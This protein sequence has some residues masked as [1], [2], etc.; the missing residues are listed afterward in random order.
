MRDHRSVT[1]LCG[2]VERARGDPDT[3][4]AWL[5]PFATPA[6][7]R[8]LDCDDAAALVLQW[9]A[10]PDPSRR[11]TDL[12]TIGAAVRVDPAAL[13]TLLADATRRCG[14]ALPG[15]PTNPGGGRGGEGP[16]REA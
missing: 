1:E 11:W 4:A 13:H 8:R 15:R 6:L 10:S 16:A 3:L 7:C 14:T 9:Y 12:R 5:Q 2:A